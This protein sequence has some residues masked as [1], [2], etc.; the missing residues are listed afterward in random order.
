[1]VENAALLAEAFAC[2]EDAVLADLHG[3]PAVALQRA[4]WSYLES[5]FFSDAERAL[6]LAEAR[7]ERVA[8]VARQRVFAAGMSAYLAGRYDLA[9]DGIASWID[10]SPSVEELR[11]ASLAASAM[12][13]AR[14]LVAADP[15]LAARVSEERLRRAAGDSPTNA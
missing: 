12:A 15:G 4:A 8:E 2:S 14:K 3:T 5:G 13:G 10:A 1:V 11:L 7:G 9:V 6:A